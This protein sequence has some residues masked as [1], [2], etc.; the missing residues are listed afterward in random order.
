MERTFVN[1]AKIK[2][3]KFGCSAIFVALSSFSLSS[4]REYSDFSDKHDGAFLLGVGGPV[5]RY[6]QICQT[7]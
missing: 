7:I 2:E 4:C 5:L 3:Q 6:A 1:I